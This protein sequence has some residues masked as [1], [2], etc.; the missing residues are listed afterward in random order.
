MNTTWSPQSC[1]RPSSVSVKWC[2]HLAFSCVEQGSRVNS[3]SAFNASKSQA[4]V[5][6]SGVAEEKSAE[7]TILLLDS[8]SASPRRCPAWLKGWQGHREWTFHRSCP[9][10]SAASLSV[11]GARSRFHCRCNRLSSTLRSGRR[12]EDPHPLS[13]RVCDLHPRR[14]CAPLINRPP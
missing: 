8:S 2:E 12:A 7:S 11:P 1:W 9:M 14:T 3:N 5:S 6:H 10:V 4:G 13:T